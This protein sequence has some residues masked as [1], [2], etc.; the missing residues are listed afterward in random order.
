LCESN[1]P[2]I[3]KASF[4]EQ[5]EPKIFEALKSDKYQPDRYNVSKLLEILTVRSLASAMTA[6]GKPKV[7]LNTLTPGFCHSELMRDAVFPLNFLGWLG[8][9]LLGRSTE[10][11]SRTLVA[12]AC[13]GEESHG[14]Y[15]ADCEVRE[16]SVWVRSEKGQETQ[17]R[18]YEELMTVLDGIEPGITGNI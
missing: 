7:I 8:K 18:V 11:G 4:K 10:M 1:S 16:V 2:A 15:M 6:S 5:F 17:K 3:Y 14:K 9:K 12:A 13:A